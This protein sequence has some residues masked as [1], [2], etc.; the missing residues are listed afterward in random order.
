MPL[1]GNKFK[2]IQEQK[3]TP[4]PGGTPDRVHGA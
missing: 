4:D 2:P 3:E 1:N